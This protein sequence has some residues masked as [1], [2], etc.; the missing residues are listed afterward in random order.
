M[1]PSAA[2]LAVGPHPSP[3]CQC[4][5]IQYICICNTH[6]TGK[7]LKRVQQKASRW[8]AIPV[9]QAQ[10]S[11]SK[12]AKPTLLHFLVWTFV[13]PTEDKN[14]PKF[15]FEKQSRKIFKYIWVT[16][17][18]ATNHPQTQW[19]KITTNIWHLTHSLWVRNSEA[20]YP[21]DSG[22]RPH[23]RLFKTLDTI[24]SSEGLIW[25]GRSTF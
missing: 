9:T 5:T 18:C 20:V 21:S 10:M 3:P 4:V 15:P 13:R 16:H 25:D 22:F 7:W 24:Q 12:T 17:C 6:K 8:K 14:D 23:R 11:N 2:L 1:S 19:Q